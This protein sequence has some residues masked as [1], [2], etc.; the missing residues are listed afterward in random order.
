MAK[1][2][3]DGFT[4][5]NGGLLRGRTTHL[6]LRSDNA[7]GRGSRFGLQCHFDYEIGVENGENEKSFKLFLTLDI[8]LSGK[9][10]ESNDDSWKIVVF[11]RHSDPHRYAAHVSRPNPYPARGMRLKCDANFARQKKDVPSTP[12][13]RWQRAQNA[14]L[15]FNKNCV[16]PKVASLQ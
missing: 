12:P 3:S 14:G 2:K 15:A 10:E 8:K 5:W 16:P 4:T 7:R 6:N 9:E 1:I 11:Y 13:D